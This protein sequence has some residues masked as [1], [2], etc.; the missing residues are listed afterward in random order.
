LIIY[1]T[2]FTDIPERE[3][4]SYGLTQGGKWVGCIWDTKPGFIAARY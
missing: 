1:L 2:P 3:L 4:I